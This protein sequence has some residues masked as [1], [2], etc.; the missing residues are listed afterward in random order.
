MPSW[1][2]PEPP[3][4]HRRI[5]AITAFFKR[6]SY[7]LCNLGVKYDSTTPCESI[8]PTCAILTERL[9]VG[10]DFGW[11]RCETEDVGL[12]VS[13]G[14]LDYLSKK[15]FLRQNFADITEV[16]SQIHQRLQ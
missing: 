15:V 5:A 13:G 9:E 1:L 7:F 8:V 11:D 4:D 10:A 14:I 6:L 12:F 16:K 3:V 2:I